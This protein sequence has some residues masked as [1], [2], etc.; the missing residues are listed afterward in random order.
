MSVAAVHRLKFVELVLAR[1]NRVRLR[2]NWG[3][4]LGLCWS[5]ERTALPD[6]PH[7]RLAKYKDHLE[8]HELRSLEF[9]EYKPGRILCESHPE[10]PMGR[11]YR[12]DHEYDKKRLEADLRLAHSRPFGGSDVLVT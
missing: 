1:S 11:C 3:T 9:I 10:R 7:Y 8:P 12:R 6:R 4:P 5:R 2:I